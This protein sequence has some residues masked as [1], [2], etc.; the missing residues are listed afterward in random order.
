[1][2]VTSTVGGLS[3][4]KSTTVRQPPKSAE[5]PAGAEPTTA[6]PSP[7]VEGKPMQADDTDLHSASLTYTSAGEFRRHRSG[8]F[9]D[10]SY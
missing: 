2:N 10:I 6:A 5:P 1:V 7:I 4:L 8:I 9:L 3:S